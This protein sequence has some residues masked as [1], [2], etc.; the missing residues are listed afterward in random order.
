MNLLQDVIHLQQFGLDERTVGS[1]DMTDV[2]EAE[3]V[4]DQ[5]V[6]V[7]SFQGA[8]QVTGHIVVNLHRDMV[9]K[10]EN[11]FTDQQDVN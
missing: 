3:V 11:T 7:V 1:T 6:P 9:H 2:V 5:N 10:R 4:E 8:I